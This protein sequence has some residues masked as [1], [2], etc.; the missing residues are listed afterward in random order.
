[1]TTDKMAGEVWHDPSRKRFVLEV[2][3]SDDPA[4]AYYQIDA[5]GRLVMTHTEVPFAASG[6][7]IGSRLA[8]GIFEIARG[9]SLRLVLRC[10]FLGAWFARHPDY[11]DVVA[12]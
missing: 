8:K 6:Q 10:P 11:G 3:G 5:E 12:G 2:E 1:M 4:Q 9:E 7:G